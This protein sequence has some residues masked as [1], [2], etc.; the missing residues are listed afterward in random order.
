[1]NLRTPAAQTATNYRILTYNQT[2]AAYADFGINTA[3]FF[4]NQ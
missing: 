1:M 3:T 4:G 2:G